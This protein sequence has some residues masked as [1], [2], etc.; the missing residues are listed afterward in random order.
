MRWFKKYF[1]SLIPMKAYMNLEGFKLFF[2]LRDI[3]GPSF[4]LAYGGQSSFINYEKSDKDLIEDYVAASDT[5]L[6]IGANIGHFT[7]Y[8]KNKFK[9][10]SCHLFEPHPVLSSCLKDT[11][12]TNEKIED[13]LIHEVALSDKEGE[14]E[15]FEDNFNDGGHSILQEKISKRSKGN[16]SFVVKTARLDDISDNLKLSNKT[17]MKIDIQGAEFLFI[18]GAKETIKKIR[19]T[20]F[21]ELENLKLSDFWSAL[22]SSSTVGYSVLSPYSKN[23]LNKDQAIELGKDLSSRGL[24]E[25]NWLF[26]PVEEQG[27]K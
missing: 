24:V 16:N 27:D 6:D 10:L 3:S 15:F 18:D 23:K 8:F 12:I 17:F 19:P 11:V 1:K 7:F 14:I 4:D 26:I 20:L 25:C 21:I 5:F 22:E 2:S 13:I 9:N